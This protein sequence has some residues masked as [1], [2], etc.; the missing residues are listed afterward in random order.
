[1]NRI[2]YLGIMLCVV[3]AL[4]PIT[5]ALE[6]D[7][8]PSAERIPITITDAGSLTV[9]AFVNGKGPY[10][11]ILDTG[12]IG[13]H[14]I[15]ERAALNADLK[16][17][18]R[19]GGSDAGGEVELWD[20]GKQTISFGG[21]HHHQAQINIDRYPFGEPQEGPMPLV[22]T[23]GSP[24]FANY[25]VEFDFK[26]MVM[27]IH[28]PATWTPPDNA[29]KVKVGFSWFSDVP[30]IRMKI[31]GEMAKLT[32]DTGAYAPFVLTSTFAEKAGLETIDTGDA[33]ST[34]SVILRTQRA[35]L[36]PINVSGQS[37]A[38]A[39]A[40]VADSQ[41]YRPTGVGVIGLGILSCQKVWF[42]FPKKAFY[43]GET[44]ASN[45]CYLHPDSGL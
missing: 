31:G 14:V 8:P 9:L 40:I 19:V 16:K 12:G 15:S 37:F 24:L 22:G 5:H 23:I 29:Q 39:S 44:Y 34:G 41:S 36:P 32:V 25:I 4:I 38:N 18:K 6:T 28:D 3:F 21:A 35:I 33:V 45:G 1:M 27:M 17:G 43:M 30:T 7:S 42:A 20:G 13:S 2:L 10:R 26:D 11:F